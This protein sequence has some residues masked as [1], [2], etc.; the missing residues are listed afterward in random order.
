M[1]KTI[2]I[3]GHEV[4]FT[5]RRYGSTTYTWASV[6][7]AGQDLDLGDPWP[8]ITPKRVELEDAARREIA[9]AKSHYGE[10]FAKCDPLVEAYRDDLL[11]HDRECLI[12]A[13]GTPYLHW[14][15]E[16]GTSL[17]VL[18]PHDSEAFPA[19]GE[20][21]PYLFGK[22]DRGKVLRD[23]QVEADYHA[24][25]VSLPTRLCL[26]FDGKALRKITT[27]RAVEIMRTYIRS[28]Q[29][30]WERSAVAFV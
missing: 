3:D 1:A 23:K 30:H 6:R 4:R 8:C 21:V 11:V 5:R 15:R 13:A 19:P 24:S 2:T 7:Y 14:T 16:T 26:H 18:W 12:R 9:L 25:P 20:S 27:D 28:V 22:A 10:L 17:A 29:H